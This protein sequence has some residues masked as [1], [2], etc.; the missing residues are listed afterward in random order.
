[1]QSYILVNATA[2]HTSG[3]LTILK[4]FL[5][6]IPIDEYEYII[7]INEN[8]EIDNKK[9]NVKLIK[10][11]INSFFRRFVWDTI[12]AKIWIRN[13]RINPIATISM[14]NTNF[15]TKKSIPNFIYFHNPFPLYEIKWNIF[16]PSQRRLWF[17]KNI[18]PFLVKLYLNKNSEVFVQIRFIKDRF[19]KKFNF[20]KN[21]IHIVTPRSELPE[22]IEPQNFFIDKKK[23]N[24][25][26]PATSFIYKNHTIIINAL[27]NLEEKF[28]R[29][30]SLYLTCERSYLEPILNKDRFYTINFIGT[31]P[32]N[33]LLGLYK[34]VDCLLFP[35]YIETYG[36]P[37]VEAASFGLPIIASDLPYAHE[38][39]ES[40]EG[41]HFA[42]FDNVDLWKEEI[43][44]LFCKKGTR[45]K[46]LQLNSKSSWDILFQILNERV[47]D[48]GLN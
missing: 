29:N 21:K 39:L 10:K 6:S 27:S 26:Y 8:I 35:S 36:L 37:L 2:S 45:Y 25:I 12:G 14:Q 23:V 32:Y 5:R 46:P 28:Q 9:P 42:S 38:V 15:R 44:K 1:M 33:Q 31:I 4:Q 43:I 47:Q 40:Y 17:Y 22:A 48:K 13:N 11:N 30:I 20:P 3:A 41:V 34:D 7:F 16:E 24:L 18:Y 19:C